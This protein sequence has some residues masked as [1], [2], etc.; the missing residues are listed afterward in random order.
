[1]AVAD[2]ALKSAPPP[3]ARIV[4]AVLALVRFVLATMLVLGR[5]VVVAGRALPY[6]CFAI[7]WV[8]S[9]AWAASVVA[10]RTWGEGSAPFVFLEAVMGAAV[11][12]SIWIIFIFLVF[13]VVLCLAYVIA[14]VSGSGSEFKKSAFGAITWGS[15]QEFL[16]F[17]RTVVLGL[18]ADVA[19]LLLCAAGILLMMMSPSVEGSISQGEIVGCVIMDVGIFGFHAISCFVIIPAFALHILREDQVD[20]KAGLTVIIIC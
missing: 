5:V 7:A 20:R 1:M 16:K 3:P 6:L 13:V 2:D 17:R 12:A 4:V 19:F 14:A 18:V 9:A 11:K 15:A 10:R 8:L